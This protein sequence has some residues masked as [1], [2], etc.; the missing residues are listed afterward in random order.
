MD[1]QFAFDLFKADRLAKFNP[2]AQ[3]NRP[4]FKAAIHQT[5]SQIT[6]EIIP[7]WHRIF[8][9]TFG[10]ISGL[11]LAIGFSTSWWKLNFS[12][13]MAIAVCFVGVALLLLQF[14]REY[15]E[16]DSLHFRIE[17]RW[18]GWTWFRACGRTANLVRVD[19]SGCHVTKTR[20]IPRLVLWE[21]CRQYKFICKHYFGSRL[22]Q[23]N[24]QYL[25]ESIQS[26]L[27]TQRNRK[28]YPSIKVK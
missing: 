5:D 26:F 13:M 24:Q 21:E 18:L 8:I 19:V 23:E 14:D 9:L 3:F 25:L 27:H 20:T 2:I 17:R 22:T 10:L 15:L 7:R 28:L 6:C 4:I 16:I 1:I 12:M 11:S